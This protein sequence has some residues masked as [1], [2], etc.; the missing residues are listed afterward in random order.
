MKIRRTV[1]VSLVVAVLV[2]GVFAG[3]AGAVSPTPRAGTLGVSVSITGHSLSNGYITVRGK[4]RV[5]NSSGH[6]VHAFCT[7]SAYENTTYR[8][9][10]TKVDMWIGRHDSKVHGWTVTGRDES[11]GFRLKA[12]ANCHT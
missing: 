4:I 9:G 7:I 2:L 11:R 12:K 6:R 10:S 1:L 5:S 8:V 3:G